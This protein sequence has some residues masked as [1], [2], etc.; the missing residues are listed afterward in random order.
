MGCVSMRQE[1]EFAV[2]AK[3]NT[4]IYKRIKPAIELR[5]APDEEEPEDQRP[6]RRMYVGKPSFDTPE[7]K[8][9][10][11]L[12]RELVVYWALRDRGLKL[13]FPDHLHDVTCGAK[14]RAGTMCKQ[15]SL[16][17][18]ARCNF[19]GG[20]S[21]G[22]TSEDGKRRSSENW[23]HAKKQSASLVSASEPHEDPMITPLSHEPS[24]HLT[25]CDAEAENL[26]KLNIAPPQKPVEEREKTPVPEQPPKKNADLLALWMDI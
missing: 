4:T 18:N 7:A 3:G 25:E 23:R 15:K 26:S 13:P 20:P 12:R 6:R 21:S 10:Y 11:D 14:T 5:Y 9:N 24:E 17:Y 8:R 16:Y 19:H 1:P 22:P 2:T